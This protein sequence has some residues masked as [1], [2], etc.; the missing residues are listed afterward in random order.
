MKILHQMGH[1]YKWPLDA[2]FQNSVG[3]G[4]IFCAYSFKE[5]AVGG[6]VSGYDP[7]DYIDKSLIDFQYYGNKSSSGGKLHTYKFHPINNKEDDTNIG[8]VGK[9]FAGIEY[10]H[11][12]GFKQVIIPNFHYEKFD[13]EKTADI[14][15]TVNKRLSAAKKPHT[16]YFMTISISADSIADD[17]YIEAL[18]QKATAMDISYDGYYIACEPIIEYKKKVSVDY[19]Y[20]TNLLKIFRVLKNQGFETIFAYANWDALVFYSLCDIDYVTIGTYEN[21]RK[22]SLSRFTEDAGGGLSKGW[23]FSEK[24]LNFIRSQE[25]VPIR[26]KGA[27]HAIANE[28]NIFSDAILD[29]SFAWNTHKPEVQKNYLLAISRLLEELRVCPLAER[30]NLMLE[31]IQSA[32]GLYEALE[33]KYNVFLQDENADYHLGSWITFIKMHSKS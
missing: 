20:Y 27:I 6:A 30:S 5:G 18:L 22:F 23:Y 2:H 26:N 7:Q 11:R 29:K 9:I 28:N 15:K 31:K 32:R 17:D 13:L 4:F 12:L 8:G 19:R 14:L 25:L 1:K 3:D 16:K 10:Q 24:L 21:L 33:K